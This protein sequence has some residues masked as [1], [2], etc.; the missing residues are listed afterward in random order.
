M[1]IRAAQ[2]KQIAHACGFELAG[3]T[4][5]LPSEDFDRFAR[6][7]A[8]GRAGEMRYLTDHR[9]D[10]RSEPRTLLPTAKSMVCVGKL[11]NTPFPKSTEFTDPDQAWISRY[12]WGEDYHTVLRRDL[13]VLVKKIGDL[14]PEPFDSKICVDTAPLLERSYAR[15]AGLGWIGKNTC[16]INQERGSWFFLAE[17]LLSIDLEPDLPPPNRCGTC[18]RCIDACPTDAI[19]PVREDE[20]TIDARL[21][22]SYLTIEKRGDLPEELQPK[23]ANHVFG[24]DICQD[25]CPWNREAP[26]S[27]E[28]VFWPREFPISLQEIAKL[29][30]PQFRAKFKDSAVLRTKYAGFVRNVMTALAN[31]AWKVRG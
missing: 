8:E 7:R 4:R 12:A 11:Y 18:R 13:E 6:W 17:V 30:E 19:V 27:A 20:W 25:V 28:Q 23:M 15:M 10:M 21:C 5:A 22:I 14:H 3:I 24:C 31:R 16:L 9:G 29:T 2:I 26:I 1:R